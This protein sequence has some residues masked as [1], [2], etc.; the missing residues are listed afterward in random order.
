MQNANSKKQKAKNSKFANEQNA[1][2]KKQSKAKSKKPES[3]LASN[4]FEARIDSCF[5]HKGPPN[6]LK[7]EFAN[8]ELILA[9]K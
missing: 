4:H 6:H 2:C 1:K 3:I 5:G 9:S 8:E 7:N